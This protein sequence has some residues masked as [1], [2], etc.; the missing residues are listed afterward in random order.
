MSERSWF[1]A[2]IGSTFRE[3]PW[4][5][6]VWWSGF[7]GAIIL[8]GLLAG[9]VVLSTLAPAPSSPTQLPAR[10]EA[11]NTQIQITNQSTSDWTGC[12]VVINPGNGD[13]GTGP[14][15]ISAGATVEGGLMTFTNEGA[16]RF[17]PGTYVVEAVEVNCNEGYYRG[18]F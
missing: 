8:F 1:E 2:L 10:V 14:V 9:L 18:T 13:W 15:R 5:Q 12:E 4:Y 3:L 7:G 6:K 17:N 11:S 16:E